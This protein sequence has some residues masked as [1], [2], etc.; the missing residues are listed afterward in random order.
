LILRPQ[1]LTL[2]LVY[3]R[4][5]GRFKRSWPS[6]QI[7]LER[8]L[9]FYS[10][11]PTQLLIAY[12]ARPPSEP[13][14]EHIIQ[15]TQTLK[16]N[17]HGIMATQDAGRSL[18][19]V[20]QNSMCFSHPDTPS[21][22]EKAH[23]SSQHFSSPMKRFLFTPSFQSD[24]YDQSPFGPFTASKFGPDEADCYEIPRRTSSSSEISTVSTP[25]SITGSESEQLTLE[26]FLAAIPS[27]PGQPNIAYDF[28][29]LWLTLQVVNSWEEL[30]DH[31]RSRPLD[32]SFPEEKH[33]DRIL[34]WIEDHEDN[35]ERHRGEY[36]PN[37][38]QAMRNL[39]WAL[40]GRERRPVTLSGHKH[41]LRGMR[42]NSSLVKIER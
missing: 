15:V 34:R 10:P 27:I 9:L 30:S 5:L 24:E 31:Y 14:F 26:V 3:I 4:R 40:L 8:I 23:I 25:G 36:E 6:H 13:S 28:R 19:L 22:T 16:N 41:R 38:R 1:P 29:Q 21:Y 35:V 17:N 42:S 2:L 11:S 32:L 39:L 7:I 12:Y 37:E 33:R 20:D 18:L